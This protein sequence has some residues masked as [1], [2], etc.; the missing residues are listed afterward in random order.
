ME[1]LGVNA[2]LIIDIVPYVEYIIGKQPPVPEMPP[3]EAQNRFNMV[4]QKFAGVFASSSHPLV[5]FLD[6]LQWIDPPSLR[7]MDYIIS[8]ADRMCMLFIGAYRENEVSP[9]HPLIMTINEWQKNRTPVSIISL[10]PLSYQ[11]IL[12]MTCE[13]V[14]S[15]RDESSNLAGLIHEKTAGN[16]FFVI[17]F[18]RTLYEEG[19]INFDKK[20]LKWLWDIEHIKSHVYTDNVIELML[21]KLRR[22]LP[23]T[24][25]ALKLASCIGNRFSY[26]TL[27]LVSGVSG[28]RLQTA[29]AEAL[30]EG[31]I[32]AM[33]DDHYAFMHDRVQ[34]AAYA[35]IPSNEKAL[36]H[37]QIGRLMLGA[38]AVEESG[39]AVFHVVHQ[40]NL[41]AQQISHPLEKLNLARLNLIAG[42]KAIASTAYEPAHQFFV[43]GMLMLDKQAW[44]EQYDL[45]RSLHTGGAETAYLIGDFEGCELLVAYI[46]ENAASAL[47]KV[48]AYEVKMAELTACGMLEDAIHAGLE[49]LAML[50]LSL[51]PKADEG[52]VR[53]E[54]EKL[55]MGSLN[56]WSGDNIAGLVELPPMKD[57]VS[58]AKMSILNALFSSAY[59]SAP[60]LMALVAVNMVD[61]SVK[62][63]NCDVSPVGYVC[64]GFVL[65]TDAGDIDNGY[66]FGRLAVDLL[67]NIDATRC[68]AKTIYL[69]NGMVR[70][71]RDHLKESIAGAVEAYQIGIQ[72][73]DFEYAARSL[74]LRPRYLYLLGEELGAVDRIMDVNSRII[75]QVKQQ[76]SLVYIQVFQE[77]VANLMGRT[78][79]TGRLA[80]GHF[81]E[82]IILPALIARNNRLG[83]FLTAYNRM[84]LYYLFQEYPAAVENARLARPNLGSSRGLFHFYEFFG[85]DSLASLAVAG[86]VPEAERL[87]IMTRVKDN[88]DQLWLWA[89]AAP[90]NHLHRWHLVEAEK[91]R[92]EERREEASYHFEKAIELAGKSGFIYEEALAWELAARMHQLCG[93]ENMSRMYLLASMLLYRKWGA[94]AKVEWMEKRHPYLAAMQVSRPEDASPIAQ[95]DA[96]SVVKASQA[97]SSEILL[98]GLMAILMRIVIETAG[99]QK[100]ALLISTDGGLSVYS[101]AILEGSEIKVFAAPDPMVDKRT[102][103]EGVVNYVS[104]ARETLILEDA[105]G[106]V[107]MSGDEYVQSRRPRS[108]LCMPIIRQKELMGLLYL[109]NNLVTGAFTPDITAVLELIASQA[110]ISIENARLYMALRQSEEEYRVIF[111][112]NGTATIIVEENTTVTL[113]NTEFARLVNYSREEIEGRMSWTVFIVP[114][115]LERMLT[116]HYGRRQREAGV[117]TKY[118]C[119]FIERNGIRHPAYI[120]IA[121]IPGTRRSVVAVVDIT[122]SR[123]YEEDRN[124]LQRLVINILNSMPSVLAGVDPAGMINM[125]NMEAQRMTGMKYDDAIGKP[126]MSLLPVMEQCRDSLHKALSEGQ[127]QKEGKVPG[128]VEGRQA[129]HDITIYP[130]L[131]DGIIGAVVRIDDVTTSVRMDEIMIQTEKMMSVGGLA[132]GMAHEIN[133]PLGGIIQGVQN[134]TRRIEGDLPAN[135][136]AAQEAGFSME[137][138]HA[139]LEKR[140]IL[141][142]LDGIWQ[143]GIRASN[144]VRNMLQFSR[145]SQAGYVSQRLEDIMERSLELAASD[146]DLERKFDFRHIEIVREYDSSLGEVLCAETE[147]E[148]VLLNLLKNSAQAFR[149]MEREGWEPCITLR[150]HGDN[151]MAVMEIEDN[152]PGME[153]SIKRRVFEPFYTTKPT[154]EGTGL[155]LSV[156]Y[157]I[158][159][160]N[161]NGQMFVESGPG[162]GTRFVIKLPLIPAQEVKSEG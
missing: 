53:T 79:N 133:N 91:A 149:G 31:L 14:H 77:S 82:D 71:S 143:S 83:I 46:L 81:N 11:N 21:G 12:E 76:T 72:T 146:Y 123:Q 116:Y 51:P 39:E 37:L 27:E 109:E 89:G 70:H 154:G 93:R 23:E 20:Q 19:L 104:R 47:D 74:T 17:Q 68:K 101:V 160:Q 94:E 57:P 7:L 10:K 48:K 141:E 35:L 158:I 5:L 8:R 153:D 122:E 50:G 15:D 73:G 34:Q 63:G 41:G 29:V 59:M 124:R 64:Y 49:I 99:A 28:S 42:E 152:G 26:D 6:D 69:F 113:A 139:Y 145:G 103:P 9:A 62:F 137:Q 128:I 140:S 66:R 162:Q 43:A 44:A 4:F 87:Q 151:G 129:F 85:Y 107:M 13:T 134:I 67:D 135:A 106:H 148:Q 119:T 33:E 75:E 97:I 65:C 127:V 30:K 18:I 24:Q 112:H 60:G 157:F 36:V 121:M 130:L 156:S 98:P 92:V 131:D 96:L 161:H 117:P 3:T 132:A 16:P 95:A 115:D 150:T 88:Q 108:I 32:I 25:E 110:A 142:F 111:E 22:L 54:L 105:A 159:T 90:V 144:I 40:L 80:G 52:I 55:H 84:F 78:G 1:A 100:G 56:Q 2:G 61:L 38:G 120:S 147:V 58:L 45:S 102:V 125:W 155:G 86:E 136:A 118:E 126:I 114:E 138:L